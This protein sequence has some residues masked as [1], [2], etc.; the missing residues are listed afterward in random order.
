MSIFISAVL[1]DFLGFAL[2]SYM[3]RYTKVAVTSFVTYLGLLQRLH[4]DRGRVALA[5]KSLRG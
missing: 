5:Y 1:D 3:I 4:G 2:L